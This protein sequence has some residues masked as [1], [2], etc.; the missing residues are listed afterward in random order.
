[1]KVAK[2]ASLALLAFGALGCGA[3]SPHPIVGAVEVALPPQSGQPNLHA[4]ADGRAILTWHEPADDGQALMFA[5]RDDAGWS[6][7]R[8]IA[9]GRDFF[10]NWADFPSLIEL[11]DGTWVVHWLEE[12]AEASYAYHVMISLSHD[13]GVT[14]GEAFS[15]HD[16]E[17]P[18][19]HGFVSM[20]P[21]RGGAALVWL[22]GRKMAGAGAGGGHG[23]MDAGE[24]TLRATTL[25]PSGELG[26]D[27]LLDGRTCECCQTSLVRAGDD[28]IAAYRDRSAEEIRNIAVV[29]L[30][31][32]EWSEPA[33][34][35]DD[36][37]RYPGCPVNGPQLAARGENVAVAW[38]TAPD[39]TPATYVAFSQDAGRTFDEPIRVDGGDPLGRVDIELLPDGRAVVVWLEPSQ[40]AA[41]ILA[42][43]V[44]GDGSIG[45]P[46]TV[47]KTSASRGS[48]FPRMALAS[49]EVVIAWTLMGESG[50][51]RVASL[52]LEHD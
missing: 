15:P 20:V 47:A 9:A 2:D 41:E 25:R 36:G 11:E 32:G 29:R 12:V 23:G 51:V 13:G 39:D 6:E 31:D 43:T 38:F 34:V 14:W 19:E 21:W 28:V 24:M 16:D 50:G 33:H 7:P 27:V 40:Q 5:V 18:T 42:R 37:W 3:E 45:A 35:H 22:D 17:S 52:R 8:V 44:A 48:G 4:T 26:E 1:M 46:V 49:D 10:V 30:T